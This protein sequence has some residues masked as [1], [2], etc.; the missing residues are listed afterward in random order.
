MLRGLRIKQKSGGCVYSTFMLFRLAITTITCHFMMRFLITLVPTF[1]LLGDTLFVITWV[2][3]VLYDHWP[4]LTAGDCARFH[5][6]WV[7]VHARKTLQ[8]AELCL[9][10][11]I[12]TFPIYSVIL[13]WPQIIHAFLWLQTGLSAK[14]WLLAMLVQWWSCGVILT[15]PIL[16]GLCLRDSRLAACQVTCLWLWLQLP[17]LNPSLPTRWA[18]T[19]EDEFRL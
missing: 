13:T 19:G 1:G 4:L 9:L 3:F 14:H 10:Y 11:I 5:L 7:F 12:L 6:E 8:M 18:I 2:T 15:D 17:A 16:T